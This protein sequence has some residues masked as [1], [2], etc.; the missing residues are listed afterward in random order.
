MYY[1]PLPTNKKPQ[2]VHKETNYIR[3]SRQVEKSF[4]SLGLQLSTKGFRATG[5]RVWGCQAMGKHFP[6]PYQVNMHLPD[7]AQPSSYL[8]GLLTH[9]ALQ[10]VGIG[11]TPNCREGAAAA[12]MVDWR[13]RWRWR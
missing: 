12:A 8:Q 2:A 13:W 6:G 10:F 4:S 5:F 9:L 1:N 11:A 3:A 7:I